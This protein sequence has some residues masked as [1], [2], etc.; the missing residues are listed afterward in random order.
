MFARQ[1]MS[2]VRCRGNLPRTEIW[3]GLVGPESGCREW[4]MNSVMFT[5]QVCCGSDFKACGESRN[6]QNEF[7][8]SS[9]A[10]LSISLPLLIA[11]AASVRG[12]MPL[13]RVEQ[14][15]MGHDH[16]RDS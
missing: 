1:Q 7:F 12:I 16:A 8:D 15:E 4:T 10:R 14:R 2:R 6:L 13:Q 11:Q 5:D 9:G 3:Q